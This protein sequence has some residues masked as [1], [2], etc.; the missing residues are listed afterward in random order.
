MII[1]LVAFSC[2]YRSAHLKILKLLMMPNKNTL[3]KTMTVNWRQKKSLS[4]IVSKYR[5]NS[6]FYCIAI[7]PAKY[8]HTL[9]TRKIWD[10]ILRPLSPTSLTGP[11][12]CQ[13]SINLKNVFQW[14]SSMTA[15]QVSIVKGRIIGW[16]NPSQYNF[17]S[18]SLNGQIKY[19]RIPSHRLRH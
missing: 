8:V 12:V 2:I 4:M 19:N 5:N 7:T 15:V 1:N 6:Q 9:F 10:I 3:Q 11:H 18:E 14:T 16:P 13:L 17:H